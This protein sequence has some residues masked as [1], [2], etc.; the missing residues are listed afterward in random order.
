MI[1]IGLG[2]NALVL[3]AGLHGRE[4]VNPVLLTKLAEEYCQAYADDAEIHHYPVK[5]LLNKCS[6]CILP[7]VNPDG[8]E[9]ALNKVL[10]HSQP[11]SPSVVQNAG[12]WSR[13]LE[14]QCQRRRYQQKFSVQIL[15]TAAVGGISRQRK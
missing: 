2:M 14:I 12:D 9:T 15:H 10:I 4:S 8:Y 3:T 13:T 7:L 6:L 11:Y 1:R 5:E